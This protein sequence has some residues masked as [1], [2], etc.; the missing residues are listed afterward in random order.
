MKLKQ[1]IYLLWMGVVSYFCFLMLLVTLPYLSFKLNVD[2]LLTKQ[3]IIHIKHWRYAFY[4]HILSSIFVLLAGVVQFW[5]YFLVRFKKWH[6]RIG[7]LYVFLILFVSGPGGLVM[8]FYAN[9]NMTAKISFV[10]L[11]VLWILFTALAFVY[12][13]KKNFVL[14]RNFMMRSY[15]LTLSAVTLRGY[16]FILPYFSHV[17][18]KQEYALL[19][20]SS[21]TIN[22]LIA[23]ALIYSKRREVFT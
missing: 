2:F 1:T 15:A 14:H 10:L 22:L 17:E 4:A 3:S 20:W 5:N 18:A 16:A 21:W 9:G 23:E 8:S 7:K 19:A 11:S 6:K 13:L 12:A